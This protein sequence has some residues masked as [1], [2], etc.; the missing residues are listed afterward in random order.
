[1][2]LDKPT[3]PAMGTSPSSMF[4]LRG[5]I[6]VPFFCQSPYKEVCLCVSEGMVF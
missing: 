4:L 3:V 6:Q 5:H 1:M 2:A